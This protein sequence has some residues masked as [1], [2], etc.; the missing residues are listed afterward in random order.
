MI[1]E[2]RKIMH[3]PDIRVSATCVRVPV[4]VSHSAG[5]HIEMQ[6]AMRPGIAKALLN[7]MLGVTVLDD[8]T[9]GQYPMPWDVT[10]EDDVFVGPVFGGTRPTSTTIIVIS[11]CPCGIVSDNLR[12]GR[13]PELHPNR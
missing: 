2:S 1:D 4:M 8:P 6:E 11:G 13:C 9:Q 7:D 3:A 10:G 12:K 5:V